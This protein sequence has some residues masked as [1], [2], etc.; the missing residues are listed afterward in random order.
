MP[1]CSQQTNL[2]FS[3]AEEIIKCATYVGNVRFCLSEQRQQIL[4]HISLQCP[5]G[6]SCYLSL[7]WNKYM[8]TR[9]SCFYFCSG[10]CCRECDCEEAIMPLD[11]LWRWFYWLSK[12]TWTLTF[13]DL[14]EPDRMMWKS[15]LVSSLMGWLRFWNTNLLCKQRFRNVSSTYIA[16]YICLSWRFKE[17]L[18]KKAS[19]SAQRTKSE[20]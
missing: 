5:F 2:S 20:T 3:A 17:K 4:S 11:C 10:S 7:P 16:C 15:L 13:G 1:S 8:C 14:K 19:K 9:P 12:P 18:H 6:G